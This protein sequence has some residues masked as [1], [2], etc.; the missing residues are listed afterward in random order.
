M[1]NYN[2]NGRR[3]SKRT[4]GKIYAKIT[5]FTHNVETEFY[6]KDDIGI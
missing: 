2:L 6:G 4:D 3:Q 5:L 1:R